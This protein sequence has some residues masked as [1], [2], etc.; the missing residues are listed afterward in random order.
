MKPD[1]LMTA[2]ACTVIKLARGVIVSPRQTAV[3]PRNHV[4]AADSNPPTRLALR[5]GRPATPCAQ[6]RARDSRKAQ[7]FFLARKRV[8]VGGMALVGRCG[9][10]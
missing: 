9:G 3:D 7:H 5:R 2:G 6:G 10:M 8:L 4:V 1:I